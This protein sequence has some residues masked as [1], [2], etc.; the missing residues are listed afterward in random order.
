MVALRGGGE[1]QGRVTSM[2]LFVG[3][4]VEVLID[5]SEGRMILATGDTRMALGHGMAGKVMV[6][7]LPG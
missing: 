2:G 1:F 4:E 5:G 3:C 7:A 6:R